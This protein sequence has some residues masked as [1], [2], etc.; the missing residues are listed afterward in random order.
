MKFPNLPKSAG[1]AGFRPSQFMPNAPPEASKTST[2]AEWSERETTTG[3]PNKR[4]K[5]SPDHYNA[6]LKTVTPDSPGIFQ[7]FPG[8][9][10]NH[11]QVVQ[12]QNILQCGEETSRNTAMMYEAEKA[13]LK[14]MSDAMVARANQRA[15]DANEHFRDNLREHAEDMKHKDMKHAEV[16]TS[17]KKELERTKKLRE[18][19]NSLLENE[20]RLRQNEQAELNAK[21]DRYAGEVE[22]LKDEIKA[23][24]HHITAITATVDS[25]KEVT[26]AKH[27]TESAHEKLEQASHQLTIKDDQLKQQ[28]EHIEMQGRALVDKDQRLWKQ[29]QQLI[30]SDQQWGGIGKGVQML[31]EKAAMAKDSLASVNTVREKLTNSIRTFAELDLEDT[32][33]KTI[34]KHVQ[35]IKQANEDFGRSLDTAQESS[36][37]ASE[38]VVSFVQSW[39][40]DILATNGT[41][42]HSEVEQGKT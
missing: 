27:A 7:P 32:G 31:K 35:V 23:L 16:V 33:T 4:R 11:D 15:H 21:E 37:A 38:F 40:N 36:Q 13:S 28:S 19:E 10:L 5:L 17:L 30:Q 24:K 1:A 42:G 34:K 26:D 9:M 25:Q 20:K 2:D 18:N 3:N 12:M 41:N 39:G 29:E 14:R 6:K 8:I 22:L